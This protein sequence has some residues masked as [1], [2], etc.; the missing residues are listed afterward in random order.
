MDNAITAKLA[1]LSAEKQAQK[2][3]LV[4]RGA[5]MEGVPFTSYHEK[6]QGLADAD[7]W[8]PNPLWTPL[9]AQRPAGGYLDLLVAVYRDRPWFGLRVSSQGNRTLTIDWGDG[10]QTQVQT[11]IDRHHHYDYDA[12]N[13]PEV[14]GR[15]KTALVTV[16]H[17]PDSPD[18]RFKTFALVRA[19]EGDQRQGALLPL[20]LLAIQGD[21]DGASG[22]VNFSLPRE[23]GGYAC[24]QLEYVRLENTAGVTETSFRNCTRL[25]AV[26]AFDFSGVTSL[27]YCFYNCQALRRV[28]PV[29]AAAATSLSRMF[30]GCVSLR[31]PPALRNTGNIADASYLFSKCAAL[32]EP[33]VCDVRRVTI[34]TGMFE[35]CTRLRRLPFDDL[36]ALSSG[37]ASLFNGCQ[38]L[39]GDLRITGK[40]GNMGEAFTGAKRLRSLRLELGGQTASALNALNNNYGLEHLRLDNMNAS[41]RTIRGLQHT[42]L[43]REAMVE[44]FGDLYDRTGLAG[45]ILELFV[46]CACYPE[47]TDEDKAV[48]QSKNWSWY[49]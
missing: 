45:G 12:L 27:A 28:S 37:M 35:G 48:A 30:E 13:S 15:Y 41:T 11:T 32:E 24:D 19:P 33:P 2:V 40:G 8:R 9:P 17:L 6:I 38:E 23:P 21:L 43:S 16:R 5:D 4:Q 31:E 25:A 3:A 42:R 22:A 14:E 20:P 7:G 10:S 47:L 34:A 39:E 26:D 18:P 49:N 46:S 29:D 44:L 1:A 36:P